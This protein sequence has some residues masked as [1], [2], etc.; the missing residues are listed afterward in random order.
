MDRSTMLFMGKSTISMAIFHSYVIYQRVLIAMRRFPDLWGSQKR[1]VCNG[2]PYENGWFE[3]TRTPIYR[4]LSLFLFYHRFTGGNCF[5][6]LFGVIIMAFHSRNSYNVDDW[7]WFSTTCFSQ[8]VQTPTDVTLFIVATC[9]NR[10]WH[11][12]STS[13]YPRLTHQWRCAQSD[14]S[15]DWLS[16]SVWGCRRMWQIVLLP[17]PWVVGFVKLYHQLLWFINILQS[18]LWYIVYIYIYIIVHIL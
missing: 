1:M 2:N 9:C 12:Y 11:W 10:I 18:I 17:H 14:F 8:D 13:P 6:V 7:W 4:Y 5:H 15:S 16:F 3:G